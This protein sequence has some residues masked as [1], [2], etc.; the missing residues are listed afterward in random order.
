MKKYI[1]TEGITDQL[2]LKSILSLDEERSD[3]QIVAAG[4]WSSAD[5]LARTLL[6]TSD[7]QVALVV[8]SDSIDPEQI[9]YRKR[10]LNRSLNEAG[11]PSRWR[12]ILIEPEIDALLFT[13][14]ELL[15]KIVGRS[16]DPFDFIR[17]RYEPNKVLKEIMPRLT[18]SS[19]YQQ[20]DRFDLSPLR[21]CPPIK[22]VIDFIE[23]ST[24]QAAA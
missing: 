21:E 5:S 7:D 11:L 17:G 18:R 20:L 4:G 3:V 6:A 14:K 16:I 19:I 13:D 15:E 2:L 22:E 12:V 24:Q 1:I 23:H 9:E 8:D 10:F